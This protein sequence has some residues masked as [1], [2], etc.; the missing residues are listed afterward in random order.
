MI[1]AS[2]SI[3]LNTSANSMWDILKEFIKAPKQGTYISNCVLKE[4]YENGF[5]RSISMGTEHGIVER[6]SLLKDQHKIVMQLENHPLYLGDTIYQI[7]SSDQEQM[8]DK[9]ITLCA[10]LSWRIRPGIIEAPAIMSKQVV[11]D[12]LLTELSGL[13]VKR[14]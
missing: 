9:R 2:S 1:Y 8:S 10:V 11:T 6:V 12:D 4:Q 5:I 13:T 3:V 7:I 14:W